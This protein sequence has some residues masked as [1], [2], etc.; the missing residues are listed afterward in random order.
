MS[1]FISR[2]EIFQVQYLFKIENLS[3]ISEITDF[4]DAL[5]CLI[6]FPVL[7]FSNYNISLELKMYL[8]ISEIT[9][10]TDVLWASFCFPH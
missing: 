8:L 1:Y 5:L 7:R 10:F 2:A 6:L 3:L 9:D 4:P